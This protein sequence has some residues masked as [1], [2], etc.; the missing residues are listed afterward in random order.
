MTESC[1]IGPLISFCLFAYNQEKFIREAVEGAFAQ[2]YSPLEIILSDDCS[3]DRTFDIMREMAVSY[4]GPHTVR[5]NRNEQNMGLI[6]HCN[7]V[8]SSAKGLL[9]VVAAGDDISVPERTSVILEAWRSNGC[10]ALAICSSITI[11]D[12]KG[13]VLREGSLPYHGIVREDRLHYL[14]YAVLFGCSAAYH[15]DLIKRGP[16]TA[17]RVED[18]PLFRRARL[19]GDVLFIKAPLVRYRQSETS[20]SSVKEKSFRHILAIGSNWLEGCA[21]Q[22]QHDA[23]SALDEHLISEAEHAD[24]CRLVE[25]ES[26]IAWAGLTITGE[27][28]RNKVRAYTTLIALRKSTLNFNIKLT[29]LL[30]PTKIA[31]Y[32]VARLEKLSEYR[33]RKAPQHYRKANVIG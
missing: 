22:L 4:R 5:L 7:A 12:E 13:G 25:Q 18:Y 6:R 20:I 9:I 24:V 29:L 32:L 27:T 2:T 19:L 16:L 28:V 10:N 15:R 33:V 11:T 3:S 14:T 23:K 21:K 1:T 17:A 31:D 8:N 30:L 26:R